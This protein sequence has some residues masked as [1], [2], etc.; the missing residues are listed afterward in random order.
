[1]VQ[2][3][4]GRSARGE[5]SGYAPQYNSRVGSS[6][7]VGATALG[8]YAVAYNVMLVPF[9]RLTSPLQEVLYAAFSRVQED[10]ERV[11]A[12]WL[13][14]NRLLAAAALP[15]LAEKPNAAMSH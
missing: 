4:A 15:A 8:M 9:S 13:R 12:V 1:M 6:I 3:W 10:T 5:L 7:P 14:V 2:D 11:R